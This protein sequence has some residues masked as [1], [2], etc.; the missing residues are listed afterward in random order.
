MPQDSEKA[1]LE[2]LW[3]YFSKKW[4]KFIF[5]DRTRVSTGVLIQSLC[6]IALSD[7]GHVRYLQGKEEA[8][9]SW[10]WHPLGIY[11]H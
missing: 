2:L 4:E 6:Q 3:I 7:L 5:T 11:L 10:Q 9:E 8:H 1:I